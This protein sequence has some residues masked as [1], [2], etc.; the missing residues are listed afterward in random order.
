[1]STRV[2]GSD[3]RVRS[4]KCRGSVKVGVEDMFGFG[5]TGRF[6]EGMA[7]ILVFFF[8]DFDRTDGGM[9]LYFGE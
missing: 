1:M 9:R 8:S 3:V 6:L 4:S 5:R 2:V 7:C